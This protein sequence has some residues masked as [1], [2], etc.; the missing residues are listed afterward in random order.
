MTVMAIS[1]TRRS[2]RYGYRMRYVEVSTAA[3]GPREPSFYSSF[4]GVILFMCLML[5][6]VNLLFLNLLFDVSIQAFKQSNYKH[7]AK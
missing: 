4:V 3:L 5:T 2:T 1:V 7:F 6:I